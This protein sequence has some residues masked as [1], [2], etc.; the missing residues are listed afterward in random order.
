MDSLVA[1]PERRRYFAHRSAR[2][3]KPPDRLVQLE[4][5]MIGLRFKLV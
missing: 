3:M 2:R 4:A 5:A 1:E